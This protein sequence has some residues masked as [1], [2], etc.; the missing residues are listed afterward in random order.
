MRTNM[1]KEKQKQLTNDL[2]ILFGNENSVRWMVRSIK[3]W[4]QS[5]QMLIEV[6]IKNFSER[7]EDINE[8]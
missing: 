4:K 7:K 2:R 1:L 8:D 6:A 5:R 3:D